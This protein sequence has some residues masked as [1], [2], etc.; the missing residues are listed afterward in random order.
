MKATGLVR[1]YPRAW[2]ERYGDE[3]TELVQSQPFR[4]RLLLDI[5]AG[6]LDARFSPQPQ[7]ARSGAGAADGG[8]RVMKLLA[9]GCETRRLTRSE[10]LAWAAVQILV[11][12]GLTLFYIAMNRMWGSKTVW[13]QAF[14]LA[15]FPMAT[16]IATVYA[17]SRGHSPLARAL[18]LLGGVVLTYL[19]GL[20]AA[21]T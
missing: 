16:V 21:W 14:G 12:V 15:V 8:G 2:R 9:I 13:I 5:L 6:A 1:L 20:L 18:L 11:T 3:F 4:P 7:V 17:Y 19:G 10:A